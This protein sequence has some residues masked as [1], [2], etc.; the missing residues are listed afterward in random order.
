M[1][2]TGVQPNDGATPPVPISSVYSPENN[3]FP[4]LEGSPGVYVDAFGNPSASPM[5]SFIQP[6]IVQ[7]AVAVT[8]SGA[9]SLSCSFRNP[10]M[11]GNSIVVCLGV[12]DMEDAVTSF[13][14][15]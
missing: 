1:A 3:T 15:S 2:F 5:M 4:A 6:R 11:G 13:A 12:G 14:I 10:V 7:Q 8:G 9:K